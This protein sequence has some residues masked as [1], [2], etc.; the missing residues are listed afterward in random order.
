MIL[1]LLIATLSLSA[2]PNVEIVA[3]RGASWDAP[4]NTLASVKL[5]WK[6]QADASEFDVYLSKDGQIVVLH[7]KNLKRTAGVDKVVTELTAAELAKLD[8]GKWKG[9]RFAGEPVALLSDVLATVPEGK[10]V[11]IEVKCGPEIVPELDRVLKTCTLKPEQTAVIAFSSDVIAAVKK[12]RPDLKAYWVVSISPRKGRNGQPDKPAPTA[13][14]LIE[15]AKRINADGL[16]LSATT[17]VLTSKYAQEIKKA[18]YPLYVWTVNTVELARTMIEVG[19]DGITTDRPQW[20]RKRLADDPSD[21]RIMSYNIRFGSANDGIN[22]WD[23][24]KD[25][26]FETI[27]DFDPDFL[28]TQ[29]TLASQRDFLAKKL[30]GYQSLAAGRDDG[31]EAGEMMAVYWKADR[32]EKLAGGHFWLSETPDVAGSKSWDS[33]LPRMATW[34]KLKDLN[35]PDAQPIL[36]VNTHFDHRGPQA[37]LESAKVIRRK[38][39]ELGTDCRLVL[40]GDFN[41][42]EGSEPYK[43]VFGEFDQKPSPLQDTFRIAHPKATQEEGTGS[44]FQASRTGGSRIDWIGCSADLHVRSAT[45]DRTARDGRTPSDHFAVT[46][47]LKTHQRQALRILSYNIHHAEGTDRKLD[48][49]RIAKIITDFK[50]DLVALQEVD[51]KTRRCQGVD[52]TAELAKLTGL[53]GTFFQAIEFEGG[54]YGQAIL[55]RVPIEESATHKLPGLPKAE[56]RIAGAAR[57]TIAGQP[58]LFVT[59]HFDHQND[60]SRQEQAKA[61]NQLFRDSPIPVIMAGDFNATPESEP[62][63]LL[64]ANWTCAQIVKEMPSIPSSQ[65]KRQIDYILYRS[66]L[67]VHVDQ[68]GVLEEPIASDHRPVFAVIERVR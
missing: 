10:R 2:G 11:F 35:Q 12:A 39:A 21:L 55:S 24:R 15:T 27:A 61:L 53:H 38:I 46:A 13:A 19:V 52:Q 14:E 41:S 30:A 62:M 67:Q 18:G 51:H 50:P 66:T 64:V 9:E 26:L 1:P 48:L 6:Q 40:T 65:P 29:E 8:V 68:A 56:Q 58:L 4:E 3:H 37:R 42:G 33:S 16:D 59:T 7:D 60:A 31:K 20:L 44:G 57:L 47:V 54:G 25:F 45:I 28:G 5:A 32:F 43:V 34:V 23:N 49:P 17:S 36:F 22:S 63:K